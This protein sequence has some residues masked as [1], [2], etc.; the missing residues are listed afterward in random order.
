MANKKVSWWVISVN[1]MAEG[2]IDEVL[3]NDIC[4]QLAALYPSVFWTELNANN[5]DIDLCAFINVNIEYIEF[6]FTNQ[7]IQYV[8]RSWDFVGGRPKERPHS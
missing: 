6:T 3:Y 8:L 1:D 4:T 2:T 5:V 7:G